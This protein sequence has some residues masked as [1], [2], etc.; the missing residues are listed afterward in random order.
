MVCAMLSLTLH[1]VSAVPLDKSA[2]MFVSP[3]NEHASTEHL[4]DLHP[5]LASLVEA[6]PFP[7]ETFTTHTFIIE[8]SHTYMRPCVE[9]M[10][11][12]LTSRSDDVSADHRRRRDVISLP[13]LKVGLRCLATIHLI[14]QRVSKYTGDL[15]LDHDTAF[16]RWF[17]PCLLYTSPSPR[18]S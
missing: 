6:K 15:G 7:A 11:L 3:M 16:V 10:P 2:D 18:D 14:I 12:P 9:K 8:S 17:Q 1:L 4:Y 13:K 5:F